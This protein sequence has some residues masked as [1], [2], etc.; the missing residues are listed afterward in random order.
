MDEG[1]KFCALLAIRKEDAYRCGEGG[2]EPA[3][4][5]TPG[6]VSDGGRR[7]K[8]NC[9]DSRRG[10]QKNNKKSAVYEVP[11]IRLV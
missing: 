7:T 3:F 8:K 5:V 6:G 1:R 4:V 10:E 11:D 9:A 2:E